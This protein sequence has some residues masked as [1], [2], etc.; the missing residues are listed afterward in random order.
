MSAVVT[1]QFRIANTTSFIESVLNDNNSYYV[2]LGLPNP[3]VAG[4]G[5]TDVSDN[6]PLAPVDNLEYQTH[7]RDSMM[8]GKKINAANIRR[9][10]KKFTWIANNRYDMYRHDYSATNLAPNSKTTNLY[11]SNFYVINSDL[12]VYI[13]LDNGSTGTSESSSAKGNRSLIEPNFTDV[14]PI[15]QSDGYTWKY[16][17]TIAASDV[18]KFDSTEYIVLPNDWSTTTN[19]QIKS[20]R[21]SGNSE[22]NKNQIKKV[23]I[24]NPGSG[25]GYISSGDTPHILNIL[26]DGT[27]AKVSV[28]VEP[29][30]IISSVKVIS[31]GSGY[32]YG[33]VDLG[34]IQTSDDNSTALGKLIPIIPPSK[35]HGFD[36]YKELG[37]DKVLIYARFDDSTK[38]WPVD[39]SFGQ[40][41]IIKNPEK[42][43]SADIYK[44]NEFS[45][46]AS[47]KISES[48]S[49]TTKNYTGVGI[50]QTVAGGIAR[51]YI[52]SYDTD[53]KIIKYFQDRSLFFAKPNDAASG[54]YDHLDT[55][56]V[57]TRANV[58][59][60]EGNN[61]IEINAPGNPQSRSIDTSLKGVTI[62]ANNKIINLGVDYINGVSESEI[63]KKTGDVIYITNRSVVQ[64]DLR[65]KEDI[66][67]V[68]EF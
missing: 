6:W 49:E 15:T 3:T 40:V 30:G 58:L 45:S 42:S 27:G 52:A 55:I 56:D 43:T 19:S 16:L 35:G 36:I 59:K 29:T 39:T 17:F 51:G 25:E 48:L 60:F 4:F 63:N 28:T 68:L 12:Q 62:T 23:Y 38:D 24:E 11:R 14:E 2:F 46:L 9:V 18:I 5:R 41:G 54:G 13:C 66:K 67:I 26:G 22:I 31:G 57:S 1:D 7:Y 64:R 20:V 34:P 61:S 47:F 32:T 37:A 53:T 10:V 21:E 65:Q 33:I 8:F 50:T 44:Q